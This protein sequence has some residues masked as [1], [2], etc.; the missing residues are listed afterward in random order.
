MSMHEDTLYPPTGFNDEEW[1]KIIILLQNA[2]NSRYTEAITIIIEGMIVIQY[3]YT[4]A[5]FYLGAEAGCLLEAIIMII[6]RYKVLPT[7]EAIMRLLYNEKN[8]YE[9]VLDKRFDDTYLC[10]KIINKISNGT[11]GNIGK[12]VSAQ[13]Q[14]ECA[15]IYLVNKI[16][17]VLCCMINRNIIQ[18]NI[19]NLNEEER[20]Y[21]IQI[22]TKNYNEWIEHFNINEVG[23]F[24]NKTF[25]CKSLD[26]PTMFQRYTEGYSKDI[27]VLYNDNKIYNEDAEYITY[28]TKQDR[29]YTLLYKIQGHNCMFI[30]M[31]QKERREKV[32]TIILLK[33]LNHDISNEFQANKV[34]ISSFKTSQNVFQR[35]QRLINLNNNLEIISKEKFDIINQRLIDAPPT[36]APA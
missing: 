26:D 28:K 21:Y 33:N 12:H 10:L 1:D 29:L 34:I 7:E 5:P 14:Y 36:P 18:I 20:E 9:R 22:K 17:Y 16:Y 32:I 13:R 11:M 27:S 6:C 30:D 15:K 24:E 8:W 3:Y 4:I 23:T 31:E 19:N 25:K 35:V 2:Y